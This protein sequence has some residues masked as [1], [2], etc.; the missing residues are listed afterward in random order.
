MNVALSA[1]AI[2]NLPLNEKEDSHPGR[3]RLAYHVYL[4]RFFMD[5][6]A[7]SGNEKQEFLAMYA[8]NNNGGDGENDDDD[9]DFNSLDT[10]PSPNLMSVAGK[11]WRYLSVDTKNGW[12]QRTAWLNSRPI[13]GKFLAFTDGVYCDNSAVLDSMSLDWARMVSLFR[14]CIT[15]RQPVNRTSGVSVLFGREKVNILNQTYRRFEINELIRLCLFGR[16]LGKLQ[17][18]E[19]VLRTK[20]TCV[21]HIASEERMRSLFTKE[22]LCATSFMI[23][24]CRNTCSR[25]VNTVKNGKLCIGYILNENENGNVWKVQLATNRICSLTKPA[26]V[27]K[28]GKYKYL[29]PTDLPGTR[30]ITEYW[31]IR[32]LLFDSGHGRLSLNRLTFDNSNKIILMKSS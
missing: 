4:S 15:R 32:L 3:E 28:E 22:G 10:P 14:S 11:R 9:S 20:K 13:P 21:I 23:K 7:L 31:P 24:Q 30:V 12:E 8:C 1:D 19:V 25:K 18:D 29:D 17:Q 2:I 27:S 6:N 26:F 16:D 5:Y